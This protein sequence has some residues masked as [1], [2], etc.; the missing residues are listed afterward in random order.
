MC[1]VEPTDDLKRAKEQPH[2]GPMTRPEA[3]TQQTDDTFSALVSVVITCY[4]QGHFV[5]DAIGSVLGQTYSGFE[6]VVIDDGS[7]DHTAEVAARY[8]MIRYV[9]QRNVGLSAARNRG[10]RE[11]RG[12]YIIFLDADDRLL[13]HA[14]EAGINALSQSPLCAFAFGSYRFI[15]SDGSVVPEPEWEQEETD[16]RMLLRR[17]CIGMHATVMYRRSV[18]DQIGAFDTDLKACEDYE[19][20]LRIAR[21]F[22]VCHHRFLVAE[23]RRHDSNMSNNAALMITAALAVIRLQ[24][25]HT[26]Q[27]RDYKRA[28]GQGLRTFASYYAAQLCSQCWVQLGS[29]HTRR[30]AVSGFWVLC[31]CYPTGALRCIMASLVRRLA[32]TQWKYGHSG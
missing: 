16:Y 12:A 19:L 7:T 23:Y 24:K 4:N 3:T 32:R 27:N 2:E 28:Y 11:S 13:P 22:P 29:P 17:N 15:A 6:I 5:D 1:T 25:R 14:I 9:H 20:Y 18:F 31:R 30:S 26:R 8:P 21:Q 10:I